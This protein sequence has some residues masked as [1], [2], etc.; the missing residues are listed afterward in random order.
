MELIKP[1]V[2]LR[3]GY[4][5]PYLENIT[6]AYRSKESIEAGIQTVRRISNGIW[7]GNPPTYQE[8]VNKLSQDDENA[9]IIDE[10]TDFI[11]QSRMKIFREALKKAREINPNMFH[12]LWNIVFVTGRFAKF[13]KENVDLLLI[14]SY[15]PWKCR[16][17]LW[18]F[19]KINWYICK[20]HGILDKTIFCLGINDSK[21]YRKSNDLWTRLPWANDEKTMRAQLGY[22]QKK[23]PGTAGIGWFVASESSIETV[24][25]ADKLSKEYF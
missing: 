20:K 10:Y 9:I 8:L 11:K 4:Y 21:E 19:F 1:V 23:C 22:I 3:N 25:L 13:C 17:L 6:L 2:F 7:W 18:L 15:W 5:I 12:A 24:Q 14:E 16:P